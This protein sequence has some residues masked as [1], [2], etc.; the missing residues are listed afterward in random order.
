MEPAITARVHVRLVTRVNQRA[1][2]HCID[3][4]NHTEKI[5]T[6]R[7]LIDAGLALRALGFDTHLASACGNLTSNE[8]R[9]HSSDDLV[10]RDIASHQI[11]VVAT[12]TV[13]CKISIIFVKPDFKSRRQLLISTSRALRQ[14]AFACLVLC[15]DF[16]K[17]SAFR[18]RIFRV[19]VIVVK[20]RAV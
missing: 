15:H 20:A 12:V 8:E 11:I 10:P 18:R 14:D 4:H 2:I 3:A 19:C 9:Q 6:L 17:S 1:A 16:P 13:P 7:D 5:S